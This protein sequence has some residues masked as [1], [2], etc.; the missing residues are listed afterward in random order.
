VFPDPRKEQDHDGRRQ[1]R[2]IRDRRAAAHLSRNGQGNGSEGV[3]GTLWA[4]YNGVTEYVDHRKLN[5]RAHDFNDARLRYV[6]FGA[7]AAIK[8]RALT[9]ALKLADPG[10]LRTLALG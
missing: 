3:K 2:A 4:A 9:H 1:I 7:G 8:Q 6:W 10:R 5:V